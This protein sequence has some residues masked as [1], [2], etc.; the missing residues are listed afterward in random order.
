MAT[1]RPRVSMFFLVG[2]LVCLILVKQVHAAEQPG[3]SSIHA[4]H[5]LANEDADD[6]R[7]DHIIGNVKKFGDDDPDDDKPEVTVLGH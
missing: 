6:T 5:D 7:Y 3:H 1:L 4:F 2:I